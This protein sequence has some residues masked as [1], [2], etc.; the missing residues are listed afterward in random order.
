MVATVERRRYSSVSHPLHL[1]LLGGFVALCLGAVISDI[2]YA[3]SYH[4][5]WQNFASWF[6][7]GSLFVGGAAIVCALL[8]L[9]PKRR[10]RGTVIHA[11]V[12][13]AAWIVAMPGRACRSDSCSR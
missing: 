7:V 10:T 5:Q 11:L 6:I 8:D 2:T 13:A 4:I 1:L 12:L 9:A 3:L